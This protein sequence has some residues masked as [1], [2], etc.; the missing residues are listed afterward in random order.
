L[1]GNTPEAFDIS[2]ENLAGIPVPAVQADMPATVLSQRPDIQSA[3]ARL[4][5]ANFDV[6]AARAAFYPSFSLTG[7]AGIVSSSLSHFFPATGLTDIAASLLQPVFSGGLL[8]GQL[9]VDRAHAVEL[10]ASYRQTVI[11]ALQDVEDALTAVER[12]Q[13]LEAI[14]QIAVES[15]RRA[16]DLAN[17]QY[18]FGAIDFLTVLTAER[19]LYQAEDALLQVHLQRLQAVVGVF[20]AL[21]GGFTPAETTAAPASAPA[22]ATGAPAQ[23]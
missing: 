21:G 6:G 15:A 13:Q 4:I 16:S 5:S 23:K 9:K 17:A 20:R 2:G 10:T 22:E 7:T 19:T 14:D 3:E 12:L 8:A 11:A 18:R 1:V